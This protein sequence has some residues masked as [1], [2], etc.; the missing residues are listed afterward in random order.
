MDGAAGERTKGYYSYQKNG[1]TI[2]ALNTNCGSLVGCT[3]DSEQGKWL[4]AQLAQ[5]P[6]KCQIA[7]SHQ[8]LFSSGLHGMIPSTKPL[9]QIMYNHQAEL[10]LSGHDHL[11]ERFAPQ[12][13]NGKADPEKGM[14]QFVVGTGGKSLYKVGNILP[15]S[16]VRIDDTFG[17]LQLDLKKNQYDWKFIDINSQVRD[18]GSGNCF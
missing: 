15:T 9:W 5:D 7:Y 4:E 16:E 12:D 13:P 17:V 6:N 11:Y 1:W 2:Y 14:R 8:P 10:F 3:P 18:S